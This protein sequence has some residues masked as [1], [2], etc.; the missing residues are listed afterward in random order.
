M[1]MG[2]AKGRSL[3]GEEGKRRKK[4]NIGDVLS[5]QE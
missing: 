5:I 3:M 2:H 4:A 1:K